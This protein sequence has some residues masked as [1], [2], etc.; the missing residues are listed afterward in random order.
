MPSRHVQVLIIGAGAAGLAAARVLRQRSVQVRVLEARDRVGGRIWTEQDGFFRPLEMGAEFVHGKHPLIWSMLRKARLRTGDADG[1]HWLWD[2]GRFRRADRVFGRAEGIFEKA[3]DPEESIQQ[4]VRRMAG[5]NSR[6]AKLAIMFTEG[7]YA[8]QPSR[9]SS[10]FIGRMARASAETSGEEMFRVLDGYG[11]LPAFLA[12]G[13]AAGQELWLNAMVRRVRWSHHHV[14]VF[15]Q[16]ARKT[17]L[18][19]FRADRALVTLPVGVLRAS[20]SQGGIVFQPPLSDKQEALRRLEMGPIVK[21]LLRFRQPPWKQGTRKLSQFGFVHAPAAA[22][23]TWWR[24][25]PFEDARL[26]GWAGGPRARRLAS[27]TESWILE[28][29][30]ESLGL[31]F[32]LRRAD[33]ERL[34]E[35]AR[36]V[37]WQADPFSLGGYC[38]VPVGAV[39]L[40]EELARPVQDTLFFAG[41]AVHVDGFAGTV[42]GALET[43]ERAAREVLRSLKHS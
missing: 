35:S 30:L 16:T 25:L 27:H 31:I 13:L 17:P 5:K 9:V 24:L 11:R 15:G 1:P 4:F 38:V 29:G 41:E 37:N 32:G 21:V 7:F 36:V 18:P 2:N 19:L 23:P 26:V 6:L 14:E 22:I 3:G 8:A 20:P 40:Q 42:H 28:R 39:P 33:L 34:L 12:R 43:G 10:T